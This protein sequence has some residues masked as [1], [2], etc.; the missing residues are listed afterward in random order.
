MSETMK[1]AVAMES[2]SYRR[3]AN[4]PPVLSGLSL[5]IPAGQWVG[6]AG[7]NG[8]GKST[9]LRLMNGLLPH[10]E[11]SIMI[12]GIPLSAETLW[13][14]RNR[15]GI[16]FANPDNQFIGQTVA[17]DIVFGMENRCLDMET[18]RTRLRHYAQMM[19]IRPLLNRHPAFL[20]GGQK[21][22][23][24]I[25]AI[26]AMEPSIVLFDEASSM[27]DVCSKRELLD[28]M[29]GMRDQGRY[30]MVSVTHDSDELA[31]SDRMIVL[32]DGSIAADGRPDELLKSE[33]LLQRCMLQTPYI[34]QVCR[35]LSRQGI[36]IGE[37]LCEKEVLDALW[38]YDS[39]KSQPSTV[40]GVLSSS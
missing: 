11:G 26:L 32:E 20:S 19:E 35:E 1:V 15:I 39:T 2:V 21:Q 7:K 27:L 12:D 40:V 5:V 8:S 4:K 9:L 31:A 30:T 24:A 36:D 6:I 18:M 13:E 28:I 34:L 37:Y 3:Q 16:V 38:E 10:C 17:E 23:V 29:R 14:I 22:R 33:S 25:A